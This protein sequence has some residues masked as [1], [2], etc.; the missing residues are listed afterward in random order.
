LLSKRR[1]KSQKKRGRQKRRRKFKLAQWAYTFE[2]NKFLFFFFKTFFFQ[3]FVIFV[4][5][6]KMKQFTRA[7]AQTWCN[8][9]CLF[10]VSWV[11]R[12]IKLIW[13]IPKYTKKK[14][15]L[16]L[17]DFIEKYFLRTNDLFCILYFGLFWNNLEKKKMCTP[18]SM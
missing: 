15:F 14:L 10:S 17:I 3:S 5:K 4:Y 7:R 11:P 2:K 6:Q 13:W 1:K 8:L 12:F 9:N 18:T 16:L